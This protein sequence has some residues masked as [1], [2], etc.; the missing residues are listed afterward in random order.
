MREISNAGDKILFFL[1]YR[2]NF[3]FPQNCCG[4]TGRETLKEPERTTAYRF[5]HQLSEITDIN[6]SRQ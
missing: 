4:I 3:A 5:Q 1:F 6:S 2:S